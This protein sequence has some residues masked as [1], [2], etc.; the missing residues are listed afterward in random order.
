[1]DVKGS[2]ST[3]RTALLL[4][5]WPLASKALTLQ[6]VMCQTLPKNH[7][8]EELKQLNQQISASLTRL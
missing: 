6:T 5:M 7:S 4:D 8:K 1:M 3:S 2:W